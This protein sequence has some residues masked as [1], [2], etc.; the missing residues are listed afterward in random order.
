[1]CAPRC[2]RLSHPRRSA[3]V[4]DRQALGSVRLE[5]FDLSGADGWR[6]TVA[7]PA[8]A[9]RTLPFTDQTQAILFAGQ[10]AALLDLPMIDL[11]G[12]PDQ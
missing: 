3:A 5:P 9:E 11:C 4:V 2:S 6:V 1:M 12:E 8:A 7:K 10:I